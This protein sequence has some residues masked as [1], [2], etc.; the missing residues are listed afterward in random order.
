MMYNIWSNKA[1]LQL[2]DIQHHICCIISSSSSTSCSYGE[3]NCTVYVCVCV[4]QT[5]Y[6]NHLK[7]FN[8]KLKAHR[9][10]DYKQIPRGGCND[11][12]EDEPLRNP[13]QTICPWILIKSF[14]VFVISIFFFSIFDIPYFLDRSI[15]LL[16]LFQLQKCS[17][18]NNNLNIFKHNLITKWNFRK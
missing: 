16:K 18:Q 13:T 5:A 6:E 3:I 2:K 10:C 1:S 12:F 8:W 4:C 7:W 17:Q 11:V 14:I 15:T 9:Q